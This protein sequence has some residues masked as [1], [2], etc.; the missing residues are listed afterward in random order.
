MK[1]KKAKQGRFPIFW[2]IVLFFAIVWL[3]S[4]LNLLDIDVPW[5]PA[6]LVIIAVGA[7]INSL[8]G[9]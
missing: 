2:A 7:I 1:N 8:R 4:E 9:A 5:I 6:I 3:L